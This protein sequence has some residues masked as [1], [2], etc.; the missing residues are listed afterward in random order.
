MDSFSF[1]GVSRRSHLPVSKGVLCLRSRR[2]SEGRL[3]LDPVSQRY[4]AGA[5]WA[6]RPRRQHDRIDLQTLVKGA[7]FDGSDGRVAGIETQ[8][9]GHV[10]EDLL[11]SQVDAEPPVSD[12]LYVGDSWV[13]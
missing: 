3:P 6:G 1:C 2:F 13:F 10:T 12:Q 8:G 11:G 7:Q 5:E 4:A 9:E